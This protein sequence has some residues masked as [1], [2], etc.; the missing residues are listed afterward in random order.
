MEWISVINKHPKY[1][2]K[3]L[4][5]VLHLEKHYHIEESKLLS[6]TQDENG[7]RENWDFTI[8]ET[9]RI[10]H[11]MPLPEPPKNK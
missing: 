3:V 2:E 7:W 6:L 11:W 4:I 5:A 1:K 10:T 9:M 8:N